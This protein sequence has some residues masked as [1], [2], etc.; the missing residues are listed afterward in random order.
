M[1][2]FDR[3]LLQASALEGKSDEYMAPLCSLTLQVT[4][5]AREAPLRV[6]VY[7]SSRCICSASFYPVAGETAEEL[8]EKLRAQR[9][10]MSEAIHLHWA[11]FAGTS[12]IDTF[13]MFRNA[14]HS[15][16]ISIERYLESAAALQER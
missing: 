10:P 11:E 14:A 6:M 3:P 4:D 5:P 9:Q 12:K 15:V 13:V 7:R 2:G 16:G 1:S 8:L